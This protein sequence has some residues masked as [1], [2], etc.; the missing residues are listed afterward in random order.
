MLA[1]TQMGLF[2]A[3]D[4]AHLRLSDLGSGV[5]LDTRRLV[6]LVPKLGLNLLRE[7]ALPGVFMSLTATTGLPLPV[8]KATLRG[9]SRFC[10]QEVRFFRGS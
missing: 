1:C 4:L 10:D 2:H 5:P 7:F 9:C 3:L 6:L 8:R